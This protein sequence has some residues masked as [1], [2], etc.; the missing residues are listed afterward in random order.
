MKDM[1]WLGWVYLAAG[2]VLVGLALPLVWGKIGPNRWYGFRVGVAMRSRAYWFAIN[3][4]WALGQIWVGVLMSLSAGLG[5]A[6]GQVWLLVV[7]YAMTFVLI[8]YVPVVWVW[9]YRLKL[10]LD[11]GRG[12][13]LTEGNR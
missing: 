9:G 11:E 3:R 1:L 13:D 7:S 6:L 12:F 4:R 10:P 5:L 2:M 8:A